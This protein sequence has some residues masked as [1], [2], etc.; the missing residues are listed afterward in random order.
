MYIPID[1]GRA[2]WHILYM[3]TQTGREDVWD[4]YT[5]MHQYLG[6]RFRHVLAP[7]F[8]TFVAQSSGIEIRMYVHVYHMQEVVDTGMCGETHS[9]V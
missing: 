7:R 5:Y 1:N 4:A 6:F 8:K 2:H 9:E 3:C